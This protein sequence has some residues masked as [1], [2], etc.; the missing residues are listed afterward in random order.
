M[1][2]FVHWVTHGIKRGRFEVG[3]RTALY[4]SV[5]VVVLTL[6][7]GLYL[8]LVSRTAA[9]GRHIQQLQAE[10]F[11]LRRENEQLEVELASE[12]SVSR[13][14]ERAIE[15]GFTSQEPVE[16]LQPVAGGP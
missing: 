11:R 16:F 10:L 13:I 14:W 9:Q 8:M 2:D 6:V 12:G 15:L 4:L 7:A 5:L 1:S 3:S